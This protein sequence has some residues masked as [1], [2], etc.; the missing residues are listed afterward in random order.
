MTTVLPVLLSSSVRLV[1]CLR[2]VQCLDRLMTLF[3]TCIGALLLV[4][5]I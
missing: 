2:S 4:S 5:T 3:I 1:T